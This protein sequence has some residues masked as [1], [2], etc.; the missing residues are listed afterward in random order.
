MTSDESTGG[1][2]ATLVLAVVA[3]AFGSLDSALN[4]AFPDLVDDLGLS[5]ADLRWVVVCFVLSYGALLV[6]AGRMGDRFDHLRVLMIGG[7]A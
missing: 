1:S 5:V 6:T 7:A 3:G 2:R 4:I